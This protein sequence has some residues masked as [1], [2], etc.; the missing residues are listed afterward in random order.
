MNLTKRG[1]LT[2]REQLGSGLLFLSA[3]LIIAPLYWRGLPCGHDTMT[4]LYRIMQLVLNGE[5]GAPFLQWG[6]HFM[7]GYGYPIFPF[8]AP[9]LYRLAALVHNIGLDVSE[10]MRL[11]GWLSLFM[12]GWGAYQL[13]RRYLRPSGA[14]VTGLAYLFAPYLIFN[15]VQR[16]AFPELL[17]LALLP[18]ALAA[19]DVAMEQR[20]RRSFITAVFTFALVTLSHNI[21][22]NFG[23]IIML[24][25]ALSRSKSIRLR[26]IWHAIT[27][28]LLIIAATL[29]VTSFF[30][31]PA[32]MELDYTQT[33]RTDSP[34]ANW[35]LFEQHFTDWSDLAGWPPEP[36]DPAL[37][38]PPTAPK[39]GVG[40]AVLAVMGLLLLAVRTF[41][42]R[43]ELLM[44]GLIGIVSLFFATA[45]SWWTWTHLPLPD[46]VQLPTRF[47][48]PASLSV[49]ILAGVVADGRWLPR[50][51][52][53]MLILTAVFVSLSGWFWLYP[54]YC[55]APT[56]P[57]AATVAQ[58]EQWTEAGDV[59][60]WNGASL[61][62]TLPRWVDT[63]PATD[64][65]TP[66]YD[67][68]EVVNRLIVPETVVLTTWQPEPNGDSY[69]LHLSKAQTV[70]YRAFYFPGWRATVNGTAI[71]L[72]PRTGD[73]LIQI[74]LPA[75]DVQLAVHFGRT[76]LRWLTL[77]FSTLV[78]IGLLVWRWKRAAQD[79]SSPLPLP[80]RRTW[81]WFV[82]TIA[83]LFLLKAGID[84]FDTPLRANQLINGRLPSITHPA[85]INFSNE[86]ML[87][88]YEGNA[89]I[90]V[91]VSADQPFTI[92]QYWTPL[93][94][95]GAPYRFRLY[96]TDNEGR[97][98]NQPFTRPSDYADLPGKHGWQ[99][100]HYARDAYRFH[101][102]PGTPSGTYWLE[103]AVF[104]ADT[105]Q[106]LMPQDAETGSNPS[107]A[108]IGQIVVEAGDWDTDDWFATAENAQV[109]TYAP[110]EIDDLTLLG[111]TVPNTV[112]RSGETVQL[113]LLWQNR[114]LSLPK[115]LTTTLSLRDGDGNTVTH[116]PIVTEWADS[117]V[118]RDQVQ[119]RLP[120]ELESG[121]YTVWLGADEPAIELGTLQ[122][123]APPHQFAPLPELVE[124]RDNPLFTTTFAELA[125]YNAEM[126]DGTISL[127]LIWYALETADESYRVFVHL[128]DADGNTI[129]QSDTIPDKW[130]RP[131]TGWVT[132]E[133][134]RDQHTLTAP[135][136]T[137]DIAIGWY[138]AATGA[139]LGE[140]IIENIQ[141][142]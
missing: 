139:R 13:G 26:A 117:A 81:G 125:G 107:H 94:N 60:L 85:A 36:A 140:T 68:G 97:V 129:A 111:W 70:T 126:M 66:F 2:A 7:R 119:W 114:P 22:P 134:I 55:D 38:N 61:G 91:A 11:V 52:T 118:V 104:R 142:K 98:W 130:T 133:Y 71:P 62:E 59:T 124:G 106:S 53:P 69:S 5:D 43:R 79:A 25:L 96:V 57:T 58:G 115:S 65:L 37:G 46:F 72:T 78:T 123:D 4:H 42:R 88:G 141:I 28:A 35:P 113:D 39:I 103:T 50:F 105:D 80:S 16:G 75:G 31:L 51:S 47:L 20:T 30:W 18:W 101:L 8:Y 86:F 137:Y 49:A 33:R 34:F 1:H 99:T 87:L 92:T 116:R 24:G 73:G 63:L 112:Y 40:Q 89:A 23:F 95:I 84:R 102:L 44:W 15:G 110:T 67:A 136:G 90:A 54:L 109:A 132:S 74:D 100:G 83:F 127:I 77:I 135:T 3:T 45:D 93:R 138:D 21:I 29:A 120:A 10:A 64:A 41:P 56:V 48:G 32:Y 6:Q 121:I 122:I 128:R 82:L 14:F 108:R 19:A 12:A 27:P 76:S 17:G 131:T 9:L